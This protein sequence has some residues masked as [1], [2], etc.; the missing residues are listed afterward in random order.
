MRHTHTHA[1]TTLYAS[2]YSCLCTHVSWGYPCAHLLPHFSHVLKPTAMRTSTRTHADTMSMC[3]LDTD[4]WIGGYTRR[5]AKQGD[6]SL[7]HSQTHTHSHPYSLFLELSQCAH[8]DTRVGRQNNA[9][10]PPYSLCRT[11][12]RLCQPS[13]EQARTC[14]CM[15]ACLHVVHS[16]ITEQIL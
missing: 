4:V 2:A 7:T 3:T 13:G 15:Y 16:I 9:R 12:G 8:L 5:H 14:V 10:S 6:H 1:R 11:R